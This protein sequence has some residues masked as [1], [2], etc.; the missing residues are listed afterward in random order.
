MTNA[1]KRKKIVAISTNARRKSSWQSIK[2]NNKYDRGVIDDHT[3]VA[4]FFFFV[5]RK[6]AAL[7]NKQFHS[8]LERM[9][10]Q[11]IVSSML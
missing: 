5:R 2:N 6:R 11:M 10:Y 7:A 3:L 8:K 1:V 4:G 9:T